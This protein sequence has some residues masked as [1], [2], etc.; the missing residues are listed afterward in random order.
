MSDAIRLLECLGAAPVAG[1]AGARA[2]MAVAEGVP[3]TQ[4]RALLD[5][6]VDAFRALAGGRRAMRCLIIS[7]E[8]DQCPAEARHRAGGKG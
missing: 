7:P 8:S 1:T 3:A 4:R 2:T 5:G 6:D